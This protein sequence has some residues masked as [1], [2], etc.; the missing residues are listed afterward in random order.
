MLRNHAGS[1]ERAA[2]RYLYLNPDTTASRF[3]FLLENKVIRLLIAYASWF[4]HENSLCVPLRNV[5][6]RYPPLFNSL[7]FATPLIHVAIPWS[8]LMQNHFPRHYVK[9]RKTHTLTPFNSIQLKEWQKRKK[10]SLR[11][12][13]TFTNQNLIRN[14]FREFHR[15]LNKLI[16]HREKHLIPLTT[17][18]TALH[19]G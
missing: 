5:M 7:F 4:V 3:S 13:I 16:V 18:F 1:L 14:K 15:P 6:W 2:K 9:E 19:L 17:W 12:L 11:Y 10:D 8:A